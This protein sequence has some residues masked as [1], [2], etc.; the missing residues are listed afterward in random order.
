MAVRL[1][2]YATARQ[3]R[4]LWTL[5]G[6]VTLVA[7]AATA[8]AQIWAGGYG[9]TPPRFPTSTT[10]SGGFNFC[11]VMFTSDRREKQGWST[12]YPGA[13]INLSIRLAELT[14]ITVTMQ[15]DSTEVP[16][17]EAVVVRLTDEALFNCPFIFMEDAGTARF[18]P[19]EVARLQDYLLKGGFLLV[20]DYHGS[21]A[22][23]QFDEEIARVL[24]PGR[25]PTIDLTPP[26]SD[27]PIWHTMF[28]VNQLPQMASINTWRRTGDVIERWNEN[29]APP[30]ARGIAD[31]QGR[32]MVLMVHNTDLP[33]PWER[34]GEDK[35]Y[36]FRFSPDAY[37]A[38]IN[39]ILYSMTH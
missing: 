11:R 38:G 24:P 18:T 8:A 21:W 25:Y 2:T 7:V 5:I 10:F 36:F 14:K 6:T 27:H 23:E 29:G 31:E 9:R 13:D 32:L 37:A 26:N 34:E 3:V 15:N 12:D 30:D 39:I 35:D 1:R 17:P 28:N 19:T 33:D 4:R 20:S 16:E 22:Q